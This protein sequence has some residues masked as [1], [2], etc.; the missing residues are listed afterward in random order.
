M[1]RRSISTWILTG[2]AAVWMAG[3]AGA[4]TLADAL[5]GAYRNSGLLEQNRAVLRAADEDVAQAVS[6]LRPVINWSGDVTRS[7][8][9]ARSGSTLGTVVGSASNT[10]NIGILAQ[11]TVFDSGRTRLGIEAAKESV[12]ATRE[13]LLSVEQQ[14]LL[15][16]VRAYMEVRRA[17]QSVGLAENNVRLITQELRAARDRFEVG[18]VTRTDVALAEARLAGARSNLAA[19]Q[20]SLVAAQEEYAN[21]VGRRPGTLAAPGAVPSVPA[22]IPGAKASA[23]R[24]HPDMRRVQRQVNVAELNIEIARAAMNPTVT[25]NG[26]LGVTETFQSDTFNH[27]GSISLEATGPIYQG[28]RLSSLVRQAMAGRDQAR[29][30]LHV[31]RHDIQQNVGNAYVQLQVA[32][33]SIQ[34]SQNQVRAAEIAFRG[35]RE[36]ATLG[37]RTTLDVLDAE[38]ELLNARNNLISA[39][40][41]EYIAAYTILSSLGLMTAEYLKLNVPRYDPAEYYNLVKDAPTLSRQGEQLDRVLRALGKE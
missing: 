20:G 2:V 28:G 17:G 27:G 35:V 4:E 12:L 41:D 5:T 11:L 39:Q 24:N 3:G 15:R 38:Q 33:A 10:V 21:A 6:A 14:I 40:V 32:R 19:A 26:R 31:V 34:A 23:M 18:E 16:A 30:N 25:L 8:G 9:T 1:K 7:F 36:E 37:A 22:N 29:G 13:S